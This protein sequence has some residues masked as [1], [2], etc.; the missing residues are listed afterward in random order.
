MSTD[1]MT[2]GRGKKQSNDASAR[3]SWTKKPSKVRIAKDFYDLKGWELERWL[4]AE[5]VDLGEGKT[6]PVRG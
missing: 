4:V 6:E 5:I 2:Q 3:A 1:L